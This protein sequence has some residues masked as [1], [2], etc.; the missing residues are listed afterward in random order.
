M[1]TNFK[2]DE[3]EFNKKQLFFD[4]L[5]KRFDFIKDTFTTEDDKKI[6]KMIKNNIQQKQA[7]YDEYIDNINTNNIPN[8]DETQEK[9]YVFIGMLE[10]SSFPSIPILSKDSKPSINPFITKVPNKTIVIDMIDSGGTTSVNKYYENKLFFNK[11]NMFN[12]LKGDL[13]QLVSSKDSVKQISSKLNKYISKNAKYYFKDD[14]IINYDIQFVAHNETENLRWLF[15]V[16]THQDDDFKII[17]NTITHKSIQTQNKLRSFFKYVQEHTGKIIKLSALL[18]ELNKLFPSKTIVFIPISCRP[19]IMKSMFNYK[20]NFKKMTNYAQ[21]YIDYFIYINLIHRILSHGNQSFK[22]L[23]TINNKSIKTPKEYK[24]VYNEFFRID[25][26]DR[27]IQKQLMK[28]SFY[29]IFDFYYK[30]LHTKDIDR[31]E[32]IKLISH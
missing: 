1:K 16:K 29:K 4:K 9:D 22:T 8:I 25:T 26:N 30:L 19:F 28:F 20:I 32:L 14:Y 17:N 7:L 23:K 24:E 27:K 21:Y 10:H 6:F 2:F 18:P 12:I 3:T 31:E 13:S 5:N 15:I 11:T